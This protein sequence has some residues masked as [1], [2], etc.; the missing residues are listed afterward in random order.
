MMEHST[1]YWRVGTDRI[2]TPHSRSWT[3]N[4]VFVRRKF[5]FRDHMSF[6]Y[7]TQTLEVEKSQNEI[8]L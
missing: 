5:S 6:Y 7:R 1:N 8:L 3:E 2:S 4:N